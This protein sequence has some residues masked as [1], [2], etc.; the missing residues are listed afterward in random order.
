MTQQDSTQVST[1]IDSLEKLEATPKGKYDRWSAEIIQ[2]ETEMSKFLEQGRNVVKKY[3]D[4]RDAVSSSQKWF[5]VFNAN[6]GILEASLYAT[7]PTIDISRKFY[8]QKDDIARVA[9]LMLQRCVQ[10]DM[11]EEESDFD[12]VMRQCVTDRLVSGLG[13][14]WLR[15]E[16]ETEDQDETDAD[17][18]PFKAIKDQDVAIDYVYWEDFLYSPCRVWGE[19]RWVGRRVPMTRDQLIK[20][21]GEKMGKRIP[22]DYATK[23]LNTTEGLKSNTVFKRACIYEIWDRENR[24]VIWFSKGVDEL[25]DVKKDP[26][27]LGDIFEPCP[28]PMFANL[29]T[30]K[31]VPKPDYVM[32]QDQ[33]SELD[34]VNNRISLLIIACKVVGVYDKS[35]DGIQRMLTEGY[36]NILIPV[37]NWAMFAEKGGVKGQVDWLP[38]EQVVQSLNQLQIHREAVK[39]QIYELTGISD[40]VRGSSKASE[41]LGAQEMK[42]KFASVRIQ[43]L[44]DEV[45][46]FAQAV[47]QIKA[48]IIVKHFDPIVIAKMSNIENTESAEFTIP[49]LEL[50]KGSEDALE[51]RV[52]IQADSMAMVDYNQQK[53]ERTEFMNAVATF[54]QSASTVG[55]GNPKL[56]PLM[57]EMLQFGIA[58]FRVSKDLESTFDKYIKE[59]NDELEAQKN[60]PPP[61]DPEMLKMQAEQQNEQQKMQMDMQM[62]QQDAQLKQQS[63]QADMQMKLQES[64]A[65]LE[66]EQQKFALLMQQMQTEFALKMQQ[67]QQEFELKMEMERMKGEQQAQLAA[68]KASQINKN[69]D[70]SE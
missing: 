68:K 19:R 42:A 26:L 46:R 60:A 35:A 45:T 18:N 52:S 62:K 4:D 10:Q 16:T 9:G 69:V 12:Q 63:Q 37:D 24:E 49:A 30:S 65:E 15:L 36:D 6:V 21:F 38:L 41:T 27:Q 28:K 20:R 17:G 43:K 55:Q 40:I 48:A 54:L 44:Q 32:I 31:C 47:L 70:N 66:M 57:L 53:T 7:I 33:Y 61:P 25:L 64:Q 3:I 1:S 58:G 11:E 59:F 13:T 67:M 14:C 29:T 34:E 56:I 39:A 51:W 8:D 23:D 2:A 50:L 22:M 5:N